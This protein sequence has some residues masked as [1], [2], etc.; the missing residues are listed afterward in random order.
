M[1]IKNAILNLVGHCK[2]LQDFNTLYHKSNTIKAAIF[3]NWS[4][5]L[6]LITIVCLSLLPAVLVYAKVGNNISLYY[7]GLV[8]GS[9]AILYYDKA[10]AMDPHYVNALTSKGLTLD[11]LGNYTGA[12]LYYDKALAIQPN[13]N[14][15]LDLTGMTL[16]KLGNFTGATQYFDKALAIDPKD[17][18]ALYNK[19]NSFDHLGFLVSKPGT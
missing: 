17:E 19:N 12:I 16:N 5:I 1:L 7:K 3:Q 11:K 14:Y 10:L 6:C 4:F 9:G 13:V 2:T 15:V 8:L 18:V